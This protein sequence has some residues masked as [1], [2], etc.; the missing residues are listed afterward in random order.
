MQCVTSVKRYVH[1]MKPLSPATSPYHQ[2]NEQS[3]MPKTPTPIYLQ[4]DIIHSEIQFSHPIMIPLPA[5]YVN[6]FLKLII[7]MDVTR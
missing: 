5:S 7:N 2:H 3:V 6:S 1:R 4:Q